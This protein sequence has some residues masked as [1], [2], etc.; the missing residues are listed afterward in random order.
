MMDCL[1]VV[2]VNI[3]VLGQKQTRLKSCGFCGGTGVLPIETRKRVSYIMM[4]PPSEVSLPSYLN[5]KI[6]RISVPR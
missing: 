1:C 5:L 4:M 3:N 6:P 2:R